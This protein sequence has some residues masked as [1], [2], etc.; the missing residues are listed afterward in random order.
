MKVCGE[1]ERE[2]GREREA[3]VSGPVFSIRP[4]TC[5][6]LLELTV[7]IHRD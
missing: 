4:L 7:H 3:S 6:L 1:I 2:E 5:G